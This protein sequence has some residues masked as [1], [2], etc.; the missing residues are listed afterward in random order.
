MKIKKTKT[1]LLIIKKL[2]HVEGYKRLQQVY[3]IAFH[4]EMTFFVQTMQF[5]TKSAIE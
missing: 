5:R 2:K 1:D 4:V 3:S